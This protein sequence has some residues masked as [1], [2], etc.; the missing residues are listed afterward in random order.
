VH[1]SSLA[2]SGGWG[3]EVRAAPCGRPRLFHISETPELARA[4]LTP[5]AKT[6]SEENTLKYLAH[7]FVY[8]D[9]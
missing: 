4:R 5:P 7:Y 1:Y 8:T 2:G 3:T 6:I 9:G